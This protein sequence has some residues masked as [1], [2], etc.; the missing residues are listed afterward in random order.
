MI[1]D[2]LACHVFLHFSRDNVFIFIEK[3]L[4]RN[5]NVPVSSLVIDLAK[6]VSVLL[7]A[8]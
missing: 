5:A 1:K 8:L 2:I 6:M 3:L 4:P 7:K